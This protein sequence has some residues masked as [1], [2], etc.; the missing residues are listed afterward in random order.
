MGTVRPVA[1]SQGTQSFM[2]SDA[3]YDDMSTR[4]VDEDIHELL[5]ETEA[6]N[7]F[8]NC[9]KVKST[10]KDAKS[11][12][13]AYRISWVD[14]DTWVP[15]YV[16]MYSKK[17]GKVCK[18]MEVKKLENISGYNTP[19]ET[20]MINLETGHRTQL[21]MNKERLIFDKP[22]NPA[23]FSKGFLQNGKVAK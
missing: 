21:V 16:E 1:A 15:V 7:D 18:T 5:S 20:E 4:E 12:Q 23:Y 22:L 8:K 2:G 13:Y 14:K 3:T 9:A 19:L 11:S 10:P 17:T 6:K